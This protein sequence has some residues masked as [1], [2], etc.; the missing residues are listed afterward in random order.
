MGHSGQASTLNTMVV[1]GR[2]GAETTAVRD[3]AGTEAE[4]ATPPVAK[5]RTSNAA[6]RN[7]P[8]QMTGNGEGG[9]A[10]RGPY[11]RVSY[12]TKGFYLKV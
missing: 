2:F 4:D 11:T 1:I 8:M 9:L 5:P 7:F 10:P 12:V 6:A 3:E